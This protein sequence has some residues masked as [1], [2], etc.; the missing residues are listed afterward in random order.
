MIASD[1][2]SEKAAGRGPGILRDGGVEVE[3]AAGEEA[4]AARAAQPALPQARPHRPAPGHPEAGDVPRRPDQ[5][6]RPATPPGSPASRAASWSTAGAPNPTRSRSASAPS[7]PTTPCSP[8]ARPRIRPERRR[9]AAPGRLR[10]PGPAAARLPAAADARRGHR[11]WSSS[12]PRPT[13]P[14][15][16]PARRRRRGPRRRRHRRA[17]LAELGRR[18]ITSLFLEGGRTLAAAFLLPS[19]STRRGPSS[20]RSCS[21]AGL[22]PRGRRCRCGPR[23][24]Q[25]P[26][27][28]L[29]SDDRDR[30][31]R[32]ADHGPLQGVVRCSPG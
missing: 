9:A 27:A 10:P 32:R 22:P 20:H 2:P 3:F 13:R 8:P 1:D 5:R 29:C 12:R 28:E 31:R 21:A 19:R 15:R 16:R 11:S 23:Q 25:D 26:R 30:G 17:R 24:R 18:G 4:T 7:S 6:P 14:R